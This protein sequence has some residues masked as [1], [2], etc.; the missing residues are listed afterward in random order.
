MPNEPPLARWRGDFIGVVGLLP[1]NLIG[2]Q[3]AVITVCTSEHVDIVDHDGRAI[4]FHRG[5]IFEHEFPWCGAEQPNETGE[6]TH[7]ES[8]HT[9][10]V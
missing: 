2:R 7:R 10:R 3:T 1:V 4:A 6:V 8:A 9:I 5:A